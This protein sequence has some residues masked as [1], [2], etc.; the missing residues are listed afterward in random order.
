MM[1]CVRGDLRLEILIKREMLPT[2]TKTRA[3]TKSLQVL[4]LF[5][6]YF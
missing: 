3:L 4:R 2:P 1:Y 5:F 6:T